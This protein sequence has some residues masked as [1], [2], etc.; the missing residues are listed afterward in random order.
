MI[1][2]LTFIGLLA[3]LAAGTALAQSSGLAIFTAPLSPSSENPPIEGVAAGGN[4]V[5]LIHMTR[6]S[7]GA[8]TR[9]VVDFQIDVAAED[10]ISASAMHI[11]R[12]ARGTNGPVVID[13][14]FGAVLDL[15]GE[16]HLFRQNIVTDSDGLAVVESLLTNPSG[17]Y[18]NMHATAPAGLRGGFVRGQLMRTDASAISS[19]QS[20]LDGMATANAALATELASVKETLARVARRL[21]VVPSN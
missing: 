20:Q 11:H 16:H 8:L 1:R 18:V 17:F 2:R 3:A 9:A 12:G 4:A 5:V 21:G 19:L 6:D 10:V 15:S 14:N 13:S 7:S